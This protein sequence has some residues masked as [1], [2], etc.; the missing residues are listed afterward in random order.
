[1]AD[2]SDGVAQGAA[3][4]GRGDWRHYGKLGFVGVIVILALVFIFQNTGKA[5]VSFLWM[6]GQMQLWIVM[7]IL[8]VAGM[9]AGFFIAWRRARRRRR[10]YR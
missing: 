5:A 8:F 10:Q 2:R 4:A 1:M 7:L 9:L 3:P 6:E